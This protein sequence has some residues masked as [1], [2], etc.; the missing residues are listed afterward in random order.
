MKNV[1]STY[2]DRWNSL[3]GAIF[4]IVVVF[5][6]LGIVPGFRQLWVRLQK[7]DRPKPVAVAEAETPSAEADSGGRP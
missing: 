5:M 6:P 3:L 4:V 2:V 1:V 7:R